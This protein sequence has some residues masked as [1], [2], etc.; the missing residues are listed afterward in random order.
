MNLGSQRRYRGMNRGQAKRLVGVLVAVLYL[1]G[2]EMP[3]P[4]FSAPANPHMRPCT[5]FP[6]NWLALRKQWEY[7]QIMRI[8]LSP[9]G[10]GSL[11]TD[12]VRHSKR[13][14]HQRV[15]QVCYPSM[16]ISSNTPPSADMQSY[17]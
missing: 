16:G 8:A 11:R 6:Q 15:V 13:S 9:I 2:T 10:L 5:M 14:W 4:T 7:S 12:I 1:A 3:L 17:G